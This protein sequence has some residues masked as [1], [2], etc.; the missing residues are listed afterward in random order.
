MY[1]GGKI[2][3]I[4]NRTELRERKCILYYFAPASHVTGIEHARHV[5]RSEMRHYEQV[6]ALFGAVSYDVS[7]EYIDA[8]AQMLENISVTMTGRFP[9][10]RSSITSS[11]ERKERWAFITGER[12]SGSNIITIRLL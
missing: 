2:I 3:C 4:M 5:V 9:I 11:L 10:F 12:I 1:P 7:E 6:K 8:M